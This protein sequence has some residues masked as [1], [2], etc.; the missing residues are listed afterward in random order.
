MS[1]PLRI[2]YPGACYHVTARGNAGQ[3]LFTDI[4]DATM[5]LDLF[6]REVLQQGWQCHGYCLVENHYHLLIE[7]PEPN[8]GRG[9]GRLNMRYSQWFGRRHRRQ[10]HLFQGRYKAILFEKDRH[11][12]EL[13]R[14]VVSNP[15]RLQAVNRAD[16]WRWSSYGALATGNDVP[17][18]LTTESVLG[19]FSGSGAERQMAWRDYVAAWDEAPSPWDNLRGGHYLGSETFLNDLADRIADKPLDQVP[20]AMADPLRPTPSEIVGAVAQVIDK[21]PA[22]VLDRRAEPEPFRA[23][24][25]LLRRAGNVPLREVA[26]LGNV[27]QGRV[28]QIQREVEEAGGLAKAF[29][30][31]EDLKKLVG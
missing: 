15:V 3:A 26:T 24:I 11:L 18:W 30:W 8:L 31:A 14:H 10:G 27:S 21:S 17:D 16:L 29:P 23:A 25:Y 9:M 4:D 22:A 12:L 13:A 19:S 6:G 2:E 28:S 7:T 5:F 20:S 1:R